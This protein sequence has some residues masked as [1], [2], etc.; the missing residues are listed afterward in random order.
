ME[1]LTIW[2][3][4]KTNDILLRLKKCVT[5]DRYNSNGVKGTYY[6]TRNILFPCALAEYDFMNEEEPYFDKCPAYR[7]NLK[8]YDC[9]GSCRYGNI[10]CHET[11]YCHRDDKEQP[12]YHCIDKFKEYYEL[13][14]RM[15]QPEYASE[16]CL[17]DNYVPNERRS[18][19]IRG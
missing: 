2:E 7:P 12:N 15:K 13:N 3:T 16:Y 17:C 4:V 19:R 10:F 18:E 1:Q 8:L 6:K 11:N 9:C 14:M 5:C